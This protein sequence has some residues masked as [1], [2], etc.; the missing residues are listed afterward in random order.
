MTD[1]IRST[2]E[3]RHLTISLEIAKWDLADAEK[4]LKW[5]KTAVASSE[6][7]YEQT[8]QQITDI[9]A[10]LESE[11]CVLGLFSSLNSPILVYVKYRQLLFL[12][13]M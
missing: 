11:R 5:L 13:Y 3:E 8:Q 9:E 6:K 12:N 1:V 4:E 10:E 2:R 7:E